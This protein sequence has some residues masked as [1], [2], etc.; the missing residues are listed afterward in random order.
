MSSK[1][2]KK[3]NEKVYINFLDVD[4]KYEANVRV[5]E[6]IFFFTQEGFLT[7]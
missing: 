7:F 3:P 6:F 5:L 4:F 2:N 1:F